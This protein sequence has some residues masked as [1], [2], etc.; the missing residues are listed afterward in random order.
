MRGDLNAYGTNAEFKNP[1]GIC[2]D[3]TG[4]YLFVSDYANHLIRRITLSNS[5]VE[6]LAGVQYPTFQTG[7]G[8]GSLSEMVGKAY[9]L[10][11]GSGDFFYASDTEM[12][13]VTK[14]YLP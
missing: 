2:L 13:T 8:E 1:S 5:K 14:L 6:Y 7:T 12:N 4:E 3:K 11:A 10:T 9:A